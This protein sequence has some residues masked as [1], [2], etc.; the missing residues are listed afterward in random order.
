VRR[1]L[2]EGR[3]VWCIVVGLADRPFVDREAEP[4][5]VLQERRVVLRTGPDAIVVLD[6]QQDGTGRGQPPDPDRVR[7]VTEMEIAR[8]R[9]GVSGPRAVGQ[10]A[11][12][13]RRRRLR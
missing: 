4:G 12:I 13:N 6:P 7:D 1:K 3:D 9:R 5:Q 11:V 10:D 2:V 8:R